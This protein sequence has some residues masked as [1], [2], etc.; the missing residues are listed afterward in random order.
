MRR[1]FSVL[2]GL[3]LLLTGCSSPEPIAGPTA[4]PGTNR[5]PT[6]EA[7]PRTASMQVPPPTRTAVSAVIP[8]ATAT[9]TTRTITAATPGSQ[10]TA[11]GTPTAPTVT[12]GAFPWTLGERST[13]NVTTPDGQQIGTANVILGGE[14][15]FLTISGSFSAGENQDRY[16]LGFDSTSYLPN[17]ELR[18]MTTGGKTTEIRTE[19]H[20]GGGTVEVVAGGVTVRNRLTL[21]A[22]Y[23]AA[24]QLPTLLRTIPFAAGYQGGIVVVPARGDTP[25]A[26]AS[27]TVV[28]QEAVKTVAGSV[29]CWRVTVVSANNEQQ[30][31][32]Y[33]VA[34]PHTL[35]RHEDGHYVYTLIRTQ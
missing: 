12:F 24:D 34:A 13:Y 26:P 35:T 20:S 21:P 29:D 3:L 2:F 8:P 16:Q 22:Q 25:V 19:F 4:Q 31:L 1:F 5:P 33:S 32:W 14:L 18:T 30:T 6:Q 23:F 17:T 28:Q 11:Q 9:I 10:A 7:A 15:Q 27:I